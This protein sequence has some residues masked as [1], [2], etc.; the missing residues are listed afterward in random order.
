[1]VGLPVKDFV[2]SCSEFSPRTVGLNMTFVTVTVA[3]TSL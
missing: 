1:M 3:K 2:G